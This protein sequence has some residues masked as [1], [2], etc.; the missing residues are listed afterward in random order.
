MAR[1]FSADDAN[2]NVG[3]IITSRTRKYSDINLMFRPKPGTGDIYVSADAAAVK[4]AVRTL[5][6]TNPFEKPFRPHIGAGI[7]NFLFELNDSFS[8]YEI[9][10][11]IR[12]TIDNYE[13]RARIRKLRVSGNGSTDAVNVYLEFQVV[14]TEELVVIETVIERLR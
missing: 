12:R 5:L 7:Q 13:P 1:K 9:E 4:Q 6:L 8:Y 11:A 3:S 2:L 10:D 14:T